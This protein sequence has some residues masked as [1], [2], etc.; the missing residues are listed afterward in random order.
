MES[1]DMGCSIWTGRNPG[2]PGDWRPTKK[3][4]KLFIPLKEHPGY[5][6]IGL[7]I[8]TPC[9]I[10]PATSSNVLRTPVS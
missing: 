6:F 9:H 7:V 1:Y 3:R 4:R 5:N 8:G 10:L 2:P